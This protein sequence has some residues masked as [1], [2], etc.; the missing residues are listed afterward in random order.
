MAPLIYFCL[1]KS[2][3]LLFCHLK[4]QVLAPWLA[5]TSPWPGP[6][7]IPQSMEVWLLGGSSTS[8]PRAPGFCSECI[9]FIFFF[10]L[11]VLGSK[12][13]HRRAELNTVLY[14]Q[15]QGGVQTWV[16]SWLAWAVMMLRFLLRDC[17]HLRVCCGC[18]LGWGSRR[19]QTETLQQELETRRT[20]APHFLFP[21]SHL[22]QNVSQNTRFTQLWLFLLERWLKIIESPR[23]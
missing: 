14:P 22:S 20:P 8:L 13:S 16:P 18:Q 19:S 10:F 3:L 1:L 6:A 5:V 15:P 12:A 21:S 2:N 23:A 4:K 7:L 11:A 17:T 9:S